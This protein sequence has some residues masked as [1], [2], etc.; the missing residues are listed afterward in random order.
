MSKV[1]D[2]N[3]IKRSLRDKIKL[4]FNGDIKAI[5]HLYNTTTEYKFVTLSMDVVVKTA[6]E[7]VLFAK[8]VAA[9]D[10]KD[11]RLIEKYKAREVA[12]SKSYEAKLK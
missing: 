3:E 1:Q 2:F 12:A 9:Q 5:L 11:R 7:N 10:Y 4:S 8:T 6:D